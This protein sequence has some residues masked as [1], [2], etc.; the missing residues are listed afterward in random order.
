MTPICVVL[1]AVGFGRGWPHLLTLVLQA[2]H[3]GET[4]LGVDVIAI[5]RSDSLQLAIRGFLLSI[6]DLLQ[7]DHRR[8]PTQSE[9]R[10]TS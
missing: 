1:A 4:D 3:V 9:A 7:S 8:H 2:K 5:A 10:R 6:D